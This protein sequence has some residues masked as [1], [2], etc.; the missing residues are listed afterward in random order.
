MLGF[1]S[2]MGLKWF[3]MLQ[4][5]LFRSASVLCCAMETSRR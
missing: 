3:C 2:W 5:V 4:Q 1:A